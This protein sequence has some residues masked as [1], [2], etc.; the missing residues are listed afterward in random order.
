M[1]APEVVNLPT[2]ANSLRQP[3]HLR[4]IAALDHLAI[5][6]YICQGQVDWHKHLDEDEL[7]L[8]QEGVITLESDRGKVTLHAEE[9]V[10]V[11]KGAYHRSSSA[12]RSTVLLIRPA[13]MS[14]RRNGHRHLYTTPDDPVLE[15][16]RLA[17]ASGTLSA[18]YQLTTLAHVEDYDLLL[19]TAHGRSPEM[20]APDVGALWLVG[21]GAVQIE[22]EVKTLTLGDGDL[23]IIPPDTRY[24]MTAPNPAWLLT[25]A[26]D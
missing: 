17:Q 2:V 21:R 5:S 1:A 7:F 6:L 25:L 20:C 18:P 4:P 9:L 10:V 11:P 16:V 24:T 14:E 13:V 23:T 3:F 22:T 12:L 26:K 19:A 15:K 8:V